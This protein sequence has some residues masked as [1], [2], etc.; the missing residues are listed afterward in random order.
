MDEKGVENHEMKKV[1]D[2]AEDV[3]RPVQNRVVPPD[4]G[5]GW[6][7]MIVNFTFNSIS[8]LFNKTLRLVLMNLRILIFKDQFYTIFLAVSSIELL[9]Q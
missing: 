5:W 2:S 7:V 4:G 6:V 8:L 3:H 9:T 1:T